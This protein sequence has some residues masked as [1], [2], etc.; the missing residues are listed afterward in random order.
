[1]AQLLIEGSRGEEVRRLQRNLNAALANQ[2]IIMDGKN[3][4]PLETKTGIFGKRT[5]AAVIQFQSDFKLKLKDGKVG[6]E[7][8]KALAMRVLVIEGSITRNPNPNPSP[9]APK[10]A[11]PPRPS[12]TPVV[13]T[14]PP[15]NKHWLFQA[16]PAAG[17][18]P[19]PFFSTAGPSASVLTGQVSF[20][21]VYRTASEGPHWEF[22]GAFQPSF[23]SQNSPTDPRYTLQLQGSVTY[24]DPYSNGRFHTAL[25]GQVVALTNLAPTSFAGGVQVGGQISLDIIEDRW[26]IFSQAGVQLTGQW[27]LCGQ[28]GGCAGQLTFGPVFTVLGTTIQWDLQ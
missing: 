14:P 4:L 13:T 9:V 22:G 28:P 12:V 27:T 11:S 1:M 24:A 23:N 26:N 19:P 7:T 25:F 3:I 18:T 2:V 8:R 17:L 5:K 20:G 15:A 10:P 6:D 21:I 16:Q